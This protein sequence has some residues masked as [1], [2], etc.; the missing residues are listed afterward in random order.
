MVRQVGQLLRPPPSMADFVKFA[1]DK[2]VAEKHS[3]KVVKHEPEVAKEV[4]PET[5]VKKVTR[6]LKKAVK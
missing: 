4:E 3:D 1:F 5:I 2:L 6:R